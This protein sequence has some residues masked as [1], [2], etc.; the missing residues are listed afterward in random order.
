MAAITALFFDVGGVLLSNGWDRNTRRQAADR[1]RLN[2]DTLEEHH[3]LVVADF[4]TGR[5]P[6]DDYLDRIIFYESRPFSR[7]EIKSFL[8]EVSQPCPESLAVAADLAAQRKYL[9][10]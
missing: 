10:A 9:M 7:E 1:F 8:F 4:E 3:E 6:L 2:W 5:L